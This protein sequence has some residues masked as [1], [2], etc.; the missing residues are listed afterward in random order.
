[1]GSPGC[2][3][4][5]VIYDGLVLLTA[6]HAV[7]SAVILFSN[8]SALECLKVSLTVHV[9]NYPFLATDD[10]FDCICVCYTGSVPHVYWEL[11]L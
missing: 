11:V 5:A 2:P 4:A 9:L 7:G 10:T 3:A 6:Q 8:Q 1:M